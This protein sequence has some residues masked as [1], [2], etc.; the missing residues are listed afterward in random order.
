MKEIEL[1]PPIKRLLEGLG[2]VVKGEVKGCDI[3]ADRK[4]EL[5]VV[6]M[7]LHFNMQLLFQAIERL[8]ITPYVFVAFPRPHRLGKNFRAAK[9]ILGK[10]GL[11]LITVALDSPVQLAEIVLFPGEHNFVEG[12]VKRK[13]KAEAL[14]KE[15]AGR[16]GDS[17]GGS[18]SRK[19]MTAYRERVIRIA[20]FAE[21]LGVVTPRE[22]V[23][24]YD[25]E[26]DA[27][28]ILLRNYYGWFIRTER[29]KYT[30]SEQGKRYLTENADSE[31]V[32]FYRGK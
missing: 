31:V 14:R 22:L 4:G 28:A 13:K 7:K 21:R 32:M 24:N 30:L 9:K 12:G 19:A 1:Y 15:I 8:D 20:C 5:W 18:K 29:G 16:I 6:E 27:G 26:K 11:G 23:Q 10:L 17:A 25:C 3:A 2:F